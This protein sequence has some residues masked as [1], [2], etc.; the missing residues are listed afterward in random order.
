MHPYEYS[1]S[2][3][4][5]H[6]T[7]DLSSVYES[8]TGISDFRPGRILRS[9]NQRTTVQGEPLSGTYKESY[10]YLDVL[11]DHQKSSIEQPGAAIERILT[12]LESFKDLLQEHSDT[13]GE[14]EFFLAFFVDANSSETF[15]PSLMKKL[16]DFNIQLAIDIYPPQNK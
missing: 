13:G 12:R 14:S 1:L 7:A 11:P 10:C 16:L 4:L 15:Y 5:R 3:R 6:P 2:F 8:L 9:G